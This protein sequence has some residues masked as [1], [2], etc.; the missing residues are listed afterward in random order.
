M[1]DEKRA[2][3]H[4]YLQL[5]RLDINM[6]ILKDLSTTFTNYVIGKIQKE[7][8]QSGFYTCIESK[9]LSNF[10]VS[11]EGLHNIVT[12]EN[13]DDVARC[14]CLLPSSRHYPCRHVI[15]V[16]VEKKRRLHGQIG[17]RWRQEMSYSEDDI[18]PESALVSEDSTSE[19]T[20]AS[21]LLILAQ[22][23]NTDPI[24]QL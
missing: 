9:E 20:G 23:R 14:S 8:G 4:A 22:H 7:C 19:E 16:A 17:N 10:T 12:W 21:T 15:R 24:F 5:Q 13:E 18:R 1:E 11:R 2:I 3:R 6:K